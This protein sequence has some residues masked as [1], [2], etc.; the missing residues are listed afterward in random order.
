MQHCAR[1][2]SCPAPPHPLTRGG[3]PFDVSGMAARVA[4]RCYSWCYSRRDSA[5]AVWLMP[6][7]S[8]DEPCRRTALIDVEI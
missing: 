1:A 7:S 8:S 6:S 4:G 3:A 2:L 5:V